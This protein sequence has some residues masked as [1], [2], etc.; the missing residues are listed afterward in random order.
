MDVVLLYVIV[1]YLMIPTL[2]L[3][4]IFRKTNY[5]GAYAFLP[6]FNG[7]ILSRI[8]GV[9]RFQLMLQYIILFVFVSMLVSLLVWLEVGWKIIAILIMLAYFASFSQQIFLLPRSFGKRDQMVAGLFLLPA[10][11]FILLIFARYHGPAGICRE[12]GSRLKR[13]A[14]YCPKCGA[15]AWYL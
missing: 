2:T 14:R 10:I 8:T 9:P 6:L 7:F 3:F 15:K 11:F 5:P 12:C 13:N 4:S 1:S